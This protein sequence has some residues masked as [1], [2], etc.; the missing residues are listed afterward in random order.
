MSDTTRLFADTDSLTVTDL[1]LDLDARNE[2]SSDDQPVWGAGTQGTFLRPL[3]QTN[4]TGGGLDSLYGSNLLAFERETFNLAPTPSSDGDASG[5]NSVQTP[6]TSTAVD[7]FSRDN[8][9][10]ASRPAAA[11]DA[12]PAPTAFIPND[13]LFAS[14][15]HLQNNAV[16]QFDLNVVDVWDDYTGAGVDVA[17]IDNAFDRVHEDLAAH[18]STVKDWDFENNDTDPSPTPGDGL[19]HGTATMGIVGAV[20]NNGVGVTGVAWGSTIFGFRVHNFINNTFLQNMS[21]AIDNASGVQQ[22]AGVDRT[23]DVVSIS[24]GTQQPGFNNFFDLALSSTD[25]ATLNTA[26]DNAAAS[27]RGGLGTILVKAAGNTRS[28]PLNQDTNSA[29]WNANNHTISVAAVD[30]D[31]TL[32]SYST[33]GA[34]VLVSGFGSPIPGQ[35]VTTDRTGADGYNGTNYTST[36]NG[37]SAATPMVSG[38][39]TLML[40]ANPGLGWRDVQEILAVS[41]RHVGTAVGGGTSGSEQYAWAFNGATEWNGGGLHFSNDYGFGLVDAKAA[42]RLA[43]TWETTRTSANDV[44]SFNDVLNAS[45]TLN[46]FNSATTFNFTP[47]T[48]IRI[49]QLKVDINFTQWYDLGDLEIHMI[50]PDGTTSILIDN[51][52][53]NDGTSAGGFGSGRWQFFSNEF[54]GMHSSGTWSLQLF[55]QDSNTVSPITINDIDITFYGSANS[56]DD[57][58]IVTNEFSNYAGL[59]GHSTNFAGGAGVNTLNAAAVDSASTIN[60]LLNSGTIDGI[61]ITN[62]NINRVFTGDGN[63]TIT[64]DGLE[65]YVDSGR[66]NDQ[67][68]A[69][70]GNQVDLTP[71]TGNDTIQGDG[72]DDLMY[73]EAGNDT[74]LYTDGQ[75]PCSSEILNGGTGSDRILVQGAGTFDFGVRRKRL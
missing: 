26:I 72:G 38:V 75:G 23:A 9:D 2:N 10:S 28:D 31:G 42:V 65:T 74:F 6:S 59:F 3:P 41:S 47:T 54:W 35:V 5:I 16:G 27:G 7:S 44:T 20:G 73:G 11:G 58:F 66:G 25:M 45:Q 40:E 49:E 62:S 46:G 60:L 63:D 22:T 15:W 56:S 69:G 21:V 64:G 33:H 34:S 61:A 39:V 36:F 43:E 14:Q 48:N 52:G 37:T 1:W 71:G 30:R 18:Y 68:Y 24:L 53:E 67:V 12:A 29:S 17:V 32:S 4:L 50:A 55:D 70:N 19:N 13:P 57:R 8:K 51:S